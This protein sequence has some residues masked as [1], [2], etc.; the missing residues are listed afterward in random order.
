MN[1]AG[2]KVVEDQEDRYFTTNELIHD[3]SVVMEKTTADKH[4]IKRTSAGRNKKALE[5]DLSDFWSWCKSRNDE[6][7]GYA[8]STWI[9][10]LACYLK[11]VTGCSSVFVMP[12]C[13]SLDGESFQ[14]PS[15]FD[16][17]EESLE[18]TGSIG[19]IGLDVIETLENYKKSFS[20]MPDSQEKSID[21]G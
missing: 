11:N 12:G 10:P 18:E 3:N 2:W 8:G 6:V 13:V 9:S 19:I 4:C 1:R 14:S 5:L 7:V 16:Y 20:A 21:L 17:V 15:W